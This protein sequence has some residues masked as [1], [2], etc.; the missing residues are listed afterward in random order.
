[1]PRRAD[2]QP[3]GKVARIG[4]LALGTAAANA[5][6]RKAF[7]DGLRDHGW[8]EGQNVAIESRWAGA[9]G[10]GL[11]ASATELA[12][13]PLD[14]IFA[15]NTPAALAAKRTGTSLPACLPRSASRW[16]SAWSRA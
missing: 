2:A 4:Y 12:R 14:V 16:R 11:D 1:M 3:A 13:M 5:G 6:S 10:A 8:I 7:I 9:G 15:V